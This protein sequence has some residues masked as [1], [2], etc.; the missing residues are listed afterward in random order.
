M[1]IAVRYFSRSGNT[2]EVAE[3]IA[4]AVGADAKDCTNAV[5]EAVDML[6]L[7]GSVYGFGLD[8]HTKSF[9][10]QLSA[11]KIKAVSVF[12]TSAIVK[13]G[14]EDMAKLIREKGI[15][16][17]SQ[18]FYCRGSFTVMHKG[19]PDTTDL[20]QATDFALSVIKESTV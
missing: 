6:F 18:S 12:G 7:G 11:D 19:H 15:K 4:K 2:K 17:M 5:T 3:A 9:I 20:K 1:N 13:S 16:V 8:E 14:N 10:S